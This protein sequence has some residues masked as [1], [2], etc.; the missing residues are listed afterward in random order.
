MR[1]NGGLIGKFNSVAITETKGIYDRF[2]NL[3][4]RKDDK[5]PKQLS[6]ASVTGLPAGSTWLENEA[7][8]MVVNFENLNVTQTVYVTYVYTNGASN[9]D[10]N[11]RPVA[12]DVTKGAS[13]SATA[14]FSLRT[15]LI[16]NPSKTTR[17]FYFEIR[18]GS[19][20]GSIIYTSPTYNIPS[21]G[22]STFSVSNSNSGVSE[23][24]TQSWSFSLTNV[25][26]ALGFPVGITKSGTATDGVDYTGIPSSFSYSFNGTYSSNFNI[27]ADTTTEGQE[28]ATMSFSYPVSSGYTLGTHSFNIADT[29]SA[30]SITSVTPNTTSATEGDTVTFTVT[31][32]NGNTGVL[33]YSLN[34]IQTADVTGGLTGSFNMTSGSGTFQV[35]LIADGVAEGES[36][37]ATVRSGSTTGTVLF[38]SGSVSIAD[39]ALSTGVNLRTS[40]H[41][42]GVYTVS[43]GSS[44]TTANYS[45]AEIQQNSSGAGRLYL[46]HKATH[47]T[48]YYN[49]AEVAC[50]QVLDSTGS[51]IKQNWWFGSNGAGW[52][53]GTTGNPL[54]GAGAGITITPTQA[55]ALSSYAS[56]I[57]P[58]S[59]ANRFNLAS[60]TASSGT[61]ALDGIPNPSPSPMTIG[62]ATMPQ[63]VGYNYIYRETSGVA[64]QSSCVCRSPSITWAVGDRIRIAYII[65]NQASGYTPTD[66]FFLGI[67]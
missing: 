61:G 31:D 27:V 35:P 2:D 44:N 10:F 19:Q 18:S 23:G 20:S 66:T 6:I 34:G 14:S 45:V 3:N 50:I 52:A 15:T 26:S 58:G 39:A 64:V 25:G 16:G 63:T 8:V 48:N 11:Y 37:T 17:T 54:G 28:T 41:S 49:D 59:I 22:A 29:S 47:A 24:T 21:V 46:I 38:T 36:F 12:F 53:T 51:T 30:P 40:F 43:D 67:N 1:G 5:W 13:T 33:Y 42:V 56:Y 65:G 32:A 62:Q 7:A 57:A 55:A 60:Y 9:S 4:Y